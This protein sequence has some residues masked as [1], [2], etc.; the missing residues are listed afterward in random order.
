MLKV[1]NPIVMP[2]KNRLRR[3]LHLKLTQHYHSHV[4]A[5]RKIYLHLAEKYGD[6]CRIYINHYPGTGDVY[7]TSALLPAWAEKEGVAKYLVTVIGKSAYKVAKMFPLENVEILSKR[8]TEDL[9][10]YLQ[11]IGE[12]APNIEVLHF[13]PFAFY[14]RIIEPLLGVN[15]SNFMDMYLNITFPGLTMRDMMPYDDQT[16]EE[17]IAEIF[18]KK[19]LVPGK[20]V[21]LSPYA[22]TIDL[23]SNQF[24][25]YLAHS[26]KSKGY[27]V[28]T[29]CDFPKERKIQGTIPVFLKYSQMKKFVETAG[30]IIQLRSGLTDLL[31]DCNCRNYILYPVENFFRFGSASLYEYFSLRK[32]GL[33]ANVKEFEFSRRNE[34][35]ILERLL[36]EL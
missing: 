25:D 1:L 10:H 5:G 13:T 8:E 34:D 23:L 27:T 16:T 28:C 31:C 24:W 21:I 2:I 36:S 6:D 20:T 17:D 18:Q 32:M 26:L 12:T 4:L 30:T 7:I 3:N 22:N 29:N 19:S 35:K 11:M 14:Q 15:G 33:N 9:L